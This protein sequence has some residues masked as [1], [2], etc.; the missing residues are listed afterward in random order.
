MAE[1]ITT[2]IIVRRRVIGSLSSRATISVCVAE[3]C[4]LAIAVIVVGFLPSAHGRSCRDVIVAAVAHDGGRAPAVVRSAG[5]GSAQA[6]AGT[7]ARP[8]CAEA[9]ARAISS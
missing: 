5:M 3:V 7:E 8:R 4:P 1:P 2:R 6:R 9:R